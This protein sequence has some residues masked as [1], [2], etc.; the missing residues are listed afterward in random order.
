MTPVRGIYV[1]R[2]FVPASAVDAAAGL[3]RAVRE[4]RTGSQEGDSS[5]SSRDDVWAALENP[6]C[7][8]DDVARVLGNIP[9]PDQQLSKLLTPLPSAQAFHTRR[10]PS[11]PVPKPTQS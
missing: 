4:C 3:F 1:E 7:K 2:S 10:M 9:P 8:L 5:Y 11:P 6:S